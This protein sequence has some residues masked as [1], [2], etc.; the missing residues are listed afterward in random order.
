M[1]E[2][3]INAIKCIHAD[4][5][6]AF[7]FA[8]LEEYLNTSNGHD[9]EAHRKSIEELES[10]FPNILSPVDLNADVEEFDEEPETSIST[11]NS[12]TTQSSIPVAHWDDYHY[13]SNRPVDKTFTFDIDDQRESHGQVFFDVGVLEGNLDEVICVT[14]EVNTNPLTGIE[15]VPCIHVAFDGSNMALHLYKV[16][17]KIILTPET[18]VR[19]R[20]FTGPVFNGRSLNTYQDTLFEIFS[21]Q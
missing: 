10:A 16:N 18:G 19:V 4:A 13:K 17:G 12:N 9:W 11:N 3:Q 1:N 7:Q 21:P 8:L 14:A 15:D 6:G 20:P 5:V 2:A